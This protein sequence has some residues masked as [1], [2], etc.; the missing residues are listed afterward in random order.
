MVKIN[1]DDMA[2]KIVKEYEKLTNGTV[3]EWNSP[4]Y[5]SIK[6]TQPENDNFIYTVFIRKKKNSSFFQN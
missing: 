1:M 3:K 5:P 2:R 4:G 6:L